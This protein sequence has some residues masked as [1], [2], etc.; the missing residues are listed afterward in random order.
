MNYQ[1]I[2]NIL[3]ILNFILLLFCLYQKIELKDEAIQH[4]FAYHH[5]ET[6][7]FTWKEK[8]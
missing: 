5:P 2:N 6:G 7:S 3:L 1:L 8:E 4:G